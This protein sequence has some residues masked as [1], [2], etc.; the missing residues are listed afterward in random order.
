MS[1]GSCH[2]THLIYTKIKC[3]NNQIVSHD[4]Y[5]YFRSCCLVLWFNLFVLVLIIFTLVL[6]IYIIF[7]LFEFYYIFLIPRFYHTLLMT[8]IVLL[9]GTDALEFPMDVTKF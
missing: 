3:G 1:I 5:I 7:Q 2:N 4:S 6:S 8:W 9:M